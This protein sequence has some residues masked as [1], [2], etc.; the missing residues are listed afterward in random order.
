LTITAL[1]VLLQFAILVTALVKLRGAFPYV[2]SLSQLLS[3]CIVIW[4]VRKHD[5]PS[6]KIAWIII[7]LLL[8]VVGTVFYLLWG[9][10]PLNRARLRKIAPISR[11]QLEFKPTA[12]RPLYKRHPQYRRLVQYL[13]SVSEMPVWE[14]TATEFYPLGEYLVEAMISDLQKAKRFIFME[15]FI[16]EPG[17]VWDSILAILT[18]KAAQGVEVRVMYDDAGC[19]STLPVGYWKTLH[20]LGIHA[21]RFNRFLPT[22]NTYLNYRDHR[23]VCVIDG[24]IAFT[25]GINL[26]DEYVNQKER[27]GHWKDTGVRLHGD[28]VSNLTAQFLQL[29]DFTTQQKTTALE[30]YLPTESAPSDG[31]VQSFSD[32]PLDDLNVSEMVFMNIIN[33]ASKYVYITSPYLTLDNEMITALCTAAQSGIDV[34]IVT[35]GIPDKK[36]VYAVTRSYYAQLIHAGV[37]IYEY[38]P[39]FLHAKMIVSDNHIAVVGTINMDFRSFYLHFECGTVF[40]RSSVVEKVKTDILDVIEQSQ[41]IDSAWLASQSWVK[42]IYASILRLFAPLL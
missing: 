12:T 18:E 9:N 21:V 29:W 33:T 7:I 42:S 36:T 25:G 35:P 14:N 32:S 2:Y 34:R 26:A 1:L 22:L 31:Y 6:Y 13:H 11:E 27:F 40:Y 39:G 3:I 10:T 16:I 41:E 17:I 4:L 19:I 8:P 23:K 37:K 30:P 15:F 20:A 38:T 5:N 24:N 28:G